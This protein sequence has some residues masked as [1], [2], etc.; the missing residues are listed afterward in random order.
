MCMRTGSR[1][2]RLLAGATGSGVS[3]VMLLGQRTQTHGVGVTQMVKSYSA[4]L[5]SGSAP[6]SSGDR[7]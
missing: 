5:Y 2:Q 7:Q 4:L 3:S 6:H 1:L